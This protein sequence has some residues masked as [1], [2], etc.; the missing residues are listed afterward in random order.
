LLGQVPEGIE[1][2]ASFFDGLEDLVDLSVQ[3]LQRPLL[4]PRSLA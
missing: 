2:V 3:I 4:A 1:S